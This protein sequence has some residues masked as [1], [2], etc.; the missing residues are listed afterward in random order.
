MTSKTKQLREKLKQYLSGLLIFAILFGQ[1]VH[2]PLLEITKAAAAEFPNLVAILVPESEFSGSLKSALKRYG[3][4]VQAN[5]DGSR[6]AIV[7]IPDDATPDKI[8]AVLERLYY[9]GDGEGN[10]R[11]V[12]TL[13]VGNLPFP[14]VH[15]G[16][17]TF[18]SVFPYVDFVD[19]SFVYKPEKAYYEYSDVPA[20]SDTPEIWHG[21]VR[22]NSGDAATDTDRMVAFFDKTHE[23]Y[24]KS[25]RF[26]PS[27]FLPEPYVFY[28]DAYHDQLASRPAEWKAYQMMLAYAEELAYNRFNK[29]LAKT[30]YEAYQGYMGND[31]PDASGTEIGKILEE[32][33]GSKLNFDNA[34]DVQTREPIEKSLKRFFEV[35]NEKYLGDILRYVHNAGRYGIGN[36]VRAD[37]PAIIVGKGDEFMKRS[38]KDANR[39]MESAIDGIVRGGLARNVAVGL[40]YK[41]DSDNRTAD[42]KDASGAVVTPGVLTSSHRSYRNFLYG[43]EGSL[44]QKAEDCTIVRGSTL[45]VEANRGYNALNSQADLALL[46][47]DR[48]G[49]K[50]FPG[51]NIAAGA[52]WGNNSP[53]KLDVSQSSQGIIKLKGNFYDGFIK[54]AFDI[55]GSKEIVPG[56][57]LPIAT[58]NDCTKRRLWVLDPFVESDEF[59]AT[60]GFPPERMGQ[61]IACTTDTVGNSTK[62]D[63]FDNYYLNGF[64]SE[65]CTTHHLRLDGAE[66]K[67]VGDWCDYADGAY[68]HIDKT[69]SYKKVLSVIEHKSPTDWEYGEELKSFV[70]PSL[71]ADKDRY[72]DFISARGNYTKIEYPN[73]FRITIANEDDLTI[74]KARELV[75]YALDKKSAEVNAIIASETP[76]GG[77]WNV[78]KNG[79]YPTGKTID[80]YAGLSAVPGLLDS[81]TNAVLWNNLSNATAKYAYALEHHLD[82]DGNAAYPV[83]G[84]KSD[85]EIAYVVGKGDAK[86]LYVKLDP[87]SKDGP[88]GEIGEILQASAQQLA[89]IDAANLASGAGG[90]EKAE[91]KCGPPDGVPLPQWLPAIFCWL[92]SILP[93]TVSAGGCAPNSPI[94]VADIINKHFNKDANGNGVP[95]YQDDSNANG[96]MDGAEYVKDG[97][98]ELQAAPSRVPYSE[99]AALAAVLYDKNGTR[100]VVDN[101]NEVSFDISR[102]VAYSGGTSSEVYRRGASGELGNVVNTRPYVNFGQVSVRAV[103]GRATFT[104]TSRDRDADVYFD[105]TVSP[106][107]KNGKAAFIKISE[108]AKLEIRSES[109][110]IGLSASGTSVST[111]LKAGEFPSVTFPIKKIGKGGQEL[112][113]SYPVAYSVVDDDTGIP[114]GVTG[115]IA[116]GGLEYSGRLLSQ[117]GNHRF[118]FTDKDGVVGTQVVTVTSGVADKI[119][120]SP[121]STLFVKGETVTVVAKVVDRYGNIVKGDLLTLQASVKG[122][123]YFV[124]NKASELEKTIVEGYTTFEITTN[125]GGKNLTFDLKT[126]DGKYS[127]STGFKSLDYAKAVVEVADRANV[128]V[129]KEA[130]AVNVKVVDAAGVTLQGFDGVAA[131]AFPELSGTFDTNFVAIKDGK[132]STG[133]LLTPKYVAGKKLA[134]DVRIPGVKDVEGNELD[135][136]PDVPMRVALETEK[137]AME[138]R[139]GETQTVT[140]RLF[141]RYGNLAYNHPENAVTAKFSVPSEFRKYLR[142]GGNAFSAES[143][144]SGGVATVTVGS[145]RLPGTPYLVVEVSPGLETNSFAVTDKS[146]STVVVSGYSKNAVVVDTYYLW[147]KSKIDKIQYNGLYTVL[148]GADYGNFT[149]RDYLGG[150][151]LFNPDSR[152]L[153]V[154]T[155]LNDA[156]SRDKVFSV[157][158]GGKTELPD[159]ESL[160]TA[161]VSTVAGR[162]SVGFYDPFYKEYVARAYFN[163]AD[164]FSKI[165]CKNDG[166]QDIDNCEVPANEPFVALKGFGEAAATAQNGLTLLRN[167]AKLLEIDAEGAVSKLPNVRL[168][169]DKEN[170]RNLF[171]VK[172]V[173]DNAVVGYLAMKL[174]SEEVAL[175]KPSELRNALESQRGKVVVETVSSRYFTVS[176]FLGNSSRGSKGLAFFSTRD[177]DGSSSDHDLVGGTAKTGFEEFRESQG[178]GWESQNKTLLEFAGG[179]SVGEATRFNA[180]FSAVNLG[181]PVFRV[182]KPKNEGDFDRTLGIRLMR[183]ENDSIEGY[184]KFDFNADGYDDLVVFLASGKIRLFANLKGSLK[185]MGYLAY[186]TDAGKFRKSVGDFAGDGYWDIMAVSKSGS[187]VLVDNREGKF[188]RK[189][190]RIF[191]ADGRES[192]LRG[193]VVQLETFDMDAD[194]K[195]DLVVSDESGELN[196]LYGGTKDGETAFT[197]KLLD[198]SLGLRISTADRSDGGAVY[199]DGLPQLSNPAVADQ[200]KY[201]AESEALAGSADTGDISPAV[202]QA[203][204]DAKLYYVHAYEVPVEYTGGT[205]N[206]QIESRLAGTI[207]NDPNNP[208]QPNTTLMDQV[209]SAMSGA[210]SLAA[211]GSFTKGGTYQETRYKTFLRSTFAEDRDVKIVKNYRDVNSDPL[212]T[213]DPVEITISITNSG[214]TR[215]RNVAYL[216]A[217]ER[218][219]FTEGDAATYRIEAPGLTKTGALESLTNSNFDFLFDGFSLNPGDTAKITYVVKTLPVSFG[220]FLVGKLETDDAYGD[221]AMRA[222][223]ICGEAM[224]VWKSVQPY[225]RSYEKTTRT[226]EGAQGNA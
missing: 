49:G 53:L 24:A 180:S 102:I 65:T 143:K 89:A 13:L 56:G 71:P 194:G 15:R 98:I 206:S 68:T 43:R 87:A 27:K 125:D 88:G 177:S 61:P 123:G 121:S 178:I 103:D 152:S 2:I 213:D 110:R 22:S 142:L 127:A 156:V 190:A 93:P 141:D 210:E 29:H 75:K 132:T 3:D 170:A 188:V 197:K 153:A 31:V 181:D 94:D 209:L 30:V 116:S 40:T 101:V 80:L 90:K 55:G 44:V 157:T 129:G 222:N 158:P 85:Y 216:D 175:T 199:F 11:L 95:D 8:A 104:L 211:S 164:G 34:P 155:Q 163:L 205:V 126:K 128:V 66:V 179:S 214:T 37:V 59:G 186:V 221:V 198:N 184:R 119:V 189:N 51:G 122:G 12:G 147:N 200:A 106:R 171:A 39:S 77:L 108:E 162:T 160:V 19:K 183:A 146:G 5:L 107:D 52:F 225:P 105:A 25:G 192:P 219:L 63:T 187:L 38:L 70:T 42:E 69:Y 139:P 16:N 58:P 165:A 32:N 99:A 79:A 62:P 166:A 4:D 172:V 33:G 220:K 60:V 226:F 207:G 182:T 218:K 185:D 18:L 57:E 1:T 131:V 91:F 86:N 224:T 134:V 48:P 136:L 212:K 21:V 191:D 97:K 195:T 26:D 217:L 173:A 74:E 83:P 10:S 76:N 140:A 113:V 17:K 117:T 204:I 151:I 167:G 169:V 124:E 161:E 45:P 111:Y 135:V 41:V 64:P 73:L 67:R 208:G 36:D 120:L 159:G 92:G 193:N 215:L 115:S 84:H 6:A 23:Y 145:T 150:E 130:H 96:I 223:N 47:A 112:A 168:E 46:Q 28:Y 72:V 81:V 148:A 14:V 202:K 138:A 114:L 201:L 174:R 176:T 78:L 9:H 154:T 149:E 20:G 196:V 144:F 133:L 35:M 109:L 50:C 118:E 203:A 7:T 82:I 54:S 100:I 137:P